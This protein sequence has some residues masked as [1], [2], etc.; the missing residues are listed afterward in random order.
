[1]NGKPRLKVDALE[2]Y[3]GRVRVLRGISLEIQRGRTTALIGRNGAG[4]TSTMRATLGLIPSSGSVRVDG[5]DVS[6]WPAFRRAQLGLGYAP[7]DRRLI[8]GMTVEENLRIPLLAQVH[9]AGLDQAGDLCREI[10]ALEAIRGRKATELSGGQQRLV[11]TARALLAGSRL[12]LLDEPFQGLAPAL[13]RENLRLID[14]WR[15]CNRDVSVLVAESDL[16]FVDQLHPDQ[17]IVIDRGTLTETRPH[18]E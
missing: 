1:M 2:V 10:P 3:Y 6:T 13:V 16:N 11:V 7:E 12:V 17:I 14:W 8:P 5:E 9:R 18:P 15:Q 4:K